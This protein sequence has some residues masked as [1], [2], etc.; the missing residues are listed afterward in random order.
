VDPTGG[1]RALAALREG[2]ADAARAGSTAGLSMTAFWAIGIG[3]ACLMLAGLV[4]W[5][6][7]NWCD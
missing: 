5:V 4:W 3:I 2:V 7:R 1:D 6:I